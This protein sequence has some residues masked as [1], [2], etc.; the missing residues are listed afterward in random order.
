M[1]ALDKKLNEFYPGK[2]VRKDLVHDI[3]KAANVPSFVLEFLLAKY[4]AT[5]DPDEIIEGKKAVL[6]I[7]EKNYV[8]PDERNKAQSM[9]EQ[10]GRHKFIDRIHVTYKERE[11]TYWAEMENFGSNR[12]QINAKFYQDNEKLLEGGVWAEVTIGYND[13]PEDD[14]AFY[15]EE[16]NQFNS[17]GLILI[18]FWKGEKISLRKNGLMLF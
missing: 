4:C 18:D 2:V 15:I 16:L 14:Y 9:V 13:I 6:E 1:D 10:K 5:D 7:V 12:I 3:K 17:P 11:K 8:R